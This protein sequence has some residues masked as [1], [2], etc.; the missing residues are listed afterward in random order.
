[1]ERILELIQAVREKYPNDDFFISIEQKLKDN[2][3]HVKKYY[4]EYNKALMTLDDESWS[5]LKIK[6]IKNSFNS[7]KGQ[8]K[9]GFFNHLNEAFAYQYLV[10]IGCTNTKVLAETN[11]KKTPD[12]SYEKQGEKQ[13]CEVKSIGISDDEVNSF[14]CLKLI[15]G[16]MLKY[17]HN[18]CCKIRY[19][20]PIGIENTICS[21][22]FIRCW[23]SRKSILR[24]KARL[25]LSNI[26]DNTSPDVSV[27]NWARPDNSIVRLSN[28]PCLK[29]ISI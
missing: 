10:T 22:L 11:V 5:I 21:K 29:Y 18:C 16:L 8:R 3:D 6:A 12:I 14:I 15:R 13:Y 9:Q 23:L 28:N 24:C 17:S 7:R 1:M 26:G 4:D 2:V 27:A 20:S 19:A 25:N